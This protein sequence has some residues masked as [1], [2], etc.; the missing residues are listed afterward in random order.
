MDDVKL[1]IISAVEPVI[2]D[3]FM[4]LV[5]IET[6]TAKNRYIRIKID[7]PGS[8]VSVDECAHISKVINGLLEDKI[9]KENYTL[10]VS[11]PGIDRPLTKPEHFERFRGKR[12]KI[13]TFEKT[14]HSNVIKGKIKDFDGKLLKLETEKKDVIIEYGNI[15][16]ANLEIEF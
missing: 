10:E 3:Y 9:I 12:A 11:S 6:G 5:E 8:G 7:K 15:K 16:K 14:E 2:K 13:I 4:E 1:E